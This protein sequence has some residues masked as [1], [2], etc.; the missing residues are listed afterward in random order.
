MSWVWQSCWWY[1]LFSVSRSLFFFPQMFLSNELTISFPKF[2]NDQQTIERY[3]FKLLLEINSF[4][5]ELALIQGQQMIFLRG[6]VHLCRHHQCLTKKTINTNLLTAGTKPQERQ[7][8][9]GIFSVLTYLT[10]EWGIWKNLKEI[11]KDSIAQ[12]AR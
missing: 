7:Y 12:E 4:S 1:S 3:F 11:N 6:Q 8:Q 5:K 9:D 2:W 10:C